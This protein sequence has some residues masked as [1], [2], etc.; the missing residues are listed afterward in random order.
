MRLSAL[1]IGAKVKIKAATE[2]IVV[3]KKN[4]ELIQSFLSEEFRK[5]VNE[6]YGL[7]RNAFVQDTIKA[8]NAKPPE[9]GMVAEL[10][11]KAGKKSW[12]F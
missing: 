9:A 10:V 5:I 6:R 7:S 2:F 8:F 3:I 12:P 11:V 1:K 4:N